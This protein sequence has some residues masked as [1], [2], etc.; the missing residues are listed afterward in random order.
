MMEQ[1]AERRMMREEEAAAS[2]EDDSEEEDD[3]DDDEEDDEDD[4]DEDEEDEE[5]VCLQLL[6]ANSF[7]RAGKVETNVISVAYHV[8][9]AENARRETNVLHLRCSNVR[10]TCTSCLS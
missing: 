9:R 10:T 4:E 2:V 1:L 5:E 7:R 8:G 6:L 3:E